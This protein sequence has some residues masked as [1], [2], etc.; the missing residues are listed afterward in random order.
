MSNKEKKNVTLNENKKTESD[1][2]ETTCCGRLFHTRTA[3]TGK[4]RSPYVTSLVRRT[5]SSC[6]LVSA[7]RVVTSSQLRSALV[8]TSLFSWFVVDMT[9]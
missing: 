5:D 1:E 6:V 3:A 7:R 8:K 2:A 4:A 9:T